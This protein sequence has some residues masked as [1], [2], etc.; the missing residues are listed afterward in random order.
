MVRGEA[1]AY[2][3]P[4]DVDDMIQGVKELIRAPLLPQHGPCSRHLVGQDPF[5]AC[6]TESRGR[7]LHR[8]LPAGLGQVPAFRESLPLVQLRKE[9]QLAGQGLGQGS[10]SSPG[11]LWARTLHKSNVLGHPTADREIPVPVGT[12]KP[13]PSPSLEHMEAALA[14][15]THWKCAEA[16]FS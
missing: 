10:F 8:L 1:H 3:V 5:N 13:R 6:G 15:D 14:Q 4:V 9:K 7:Q 2:D 12:A 11:E 16:F